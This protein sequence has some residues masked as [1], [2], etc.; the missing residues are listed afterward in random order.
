MTLAFMKPY[1]IALAA[2]MSTWRI[3]DISIASMRGF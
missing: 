3:L 2:A 1:I